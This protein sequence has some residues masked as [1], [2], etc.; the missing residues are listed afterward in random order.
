MKTCLSLVYLA[1]GL[2]SFLNVWITDWAFQFVEI[3]LLMNVLFGSMLSRDKNIWSAQLER[4]D[5]LKTLSQRESS[6]RWRLW[7]QQ[8]FL[9]CVLWHELMEDLRLWQN[10][11]YFF[12]IY[13][14]EFT[15]FFTPRKATWQSPV[16]NDYIC[17]WHKSRLLNR[18]TLELSHVAA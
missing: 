6:L 17:L 8:Y 18:S 1:V 16:H 2:Y 15:L 12:R 7:L 5:H 9:N 13:W 11:I 4:S 3:K 14:N 10:Y